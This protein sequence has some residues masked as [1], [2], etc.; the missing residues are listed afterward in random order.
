MIDYNT[1]FK[2]APT[3][4]PD[5]YSP[6]PYRSSDHDPV[7]IGLDLKIENDLSDLPAPYDAAWHT[8]SEISLGA[9]WEA[10]HSPVGGGTNDGVV[11]TPNVSWSHAA[12]GSVD[13]TV[14]GSGYVTGWIDWN[15]DGDFG[16]TG[17]QIFANEDFTA[18]AVRTITF[19][20]PDVTV[21]GATLNARF[22]LY[23]D[24]QT[25]LAAAAAP[26]A[27]DAAP[28]P[29]GGATGGEVEDY[30]WTGNPTAVTLSHLS[31]AGVSITGWP[32]AAGLGALGI[33][34]L[35]RRRR[36]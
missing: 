14:A 27:P 1:E 12:G 31:A 26:D 34:L 4:S 10:G 24:I 15:N 2:G 9:T 21:A 3:Y 25:A 8:F 13:V 6:T 18:Q 29:L 23:R 32:A 5:L 11:R 7:I 17:E 30:T 20:I 22:R 16:D 28:S 35:A 36:K 19:P 33:V